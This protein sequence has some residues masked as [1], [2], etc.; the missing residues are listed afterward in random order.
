MPFYASQSCYNS[1]RVYIYIGSS[2]LD[3]DH[4]STEVPTNYSISLLAYSR[5][6][7]QGIPS[8]NYHHYSCYSHPYYQGIPRPDTDQFSIFG[9]T[10]RAYLIVTGIRY[11]LTDQYRDATSGHSPQGLLRFNQS[12]L[13]SS[14][15]W[16]I[17]WRGRTAW[18][19]DLPWDLPLSTWFSS[20]LTI[21]P[22]FLELELLHLHLV[23]PLQLLFRIRWRHIYR[24]KQ[25]VW[26][27]K[28]A[29]RILRQMYLQSTGQSHMLQMFQNRAPRN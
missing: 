5:R 28:I 16:S 22:T 10:Y 24:V 9:D 23:L 4:S 3:H 20:S 15:C 29:W 25:M 21:I 6:P 12:G 27:L 2:Y 18:K 26:V 13:A 19:L 11:R 8:P 7:Y 17:I 1:N 14:K